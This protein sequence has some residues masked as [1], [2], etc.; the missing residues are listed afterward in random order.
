LCSRSVALPGGRAGSEAAL[1][2]SLAH[3][4]VIDRAAGQ[5]LP[6]P[7]G[8]THPRA[9]RLAQ[10]RREVLRVAIVEEDDAVL[11]I[12]DDEP[13]GHALRR[14]LEAGLAGGEAGLVGPTPGEGLA[15]R[16]EPGLP[17]C[18]YPRRREHLARRLGPDLPHQQECRPHEALPQQ[19]LG[20]SQREQEQG[21]RGHV[22]H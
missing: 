15:N 5:A 11:R 21:G 8:E 7:V 18:R 4:G 1:R 9:Q 6:D 2:V 17:G 14:G 10:R 19:D 12:E 20:C 3:V 13:V 16:V 22:G